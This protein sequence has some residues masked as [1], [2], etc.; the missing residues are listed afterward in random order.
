MKTEDKIYTEHAEHSDWMSK[1]KFY[2]DEICILKDRLSEIVSKNNHKDV[3]AEA[4]HFQNQFVV[5]KD[6][7]DEISHTITVDEDM[8]QKAVDKKPK[9]IDHLDTKSHTKEKAA[10]EAFEKNFR[11]LR[12][13]FNQF[14]IKWM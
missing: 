8:I 9:F 14:A 3:L 10:V 1:L 6:N 5:Q 12:E 7:I 13:E 4:E 11:E 2:D